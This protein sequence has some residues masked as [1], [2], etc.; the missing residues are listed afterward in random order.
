MYG[1]LFTVIVFLMSVFSIYSKDYNYTDFSYWWGGDSYNRY[2]FNYVRN[3]STSFFGGGGYEYYE[4]KKNRGNT[5]KLN[6]GFIS[7]NYVFSIKPFYFLKESGGYAFGAK[8][9]ADI[10]SGN[11]ELTRNLILNLGTVQKRGKIEHSD[12]LGEMQ[13][14]FNFDDHL[15]L[16]ARSSYNFKP[17]KIITPFDY[18]SFWGYNYLGTIND[19]FYSDI[20]FGYGRSFKPDFNSYLY[21]SFDRINTSGDDINSYLIGL[22]TYLDDDEK[23]FIDLDYNYADFKKNDNEKHY[24]LIMGVVF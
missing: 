11:Q 12:F 18:S 7:K 13:I 20:G 24:R 14:E 3:I 9:G 19:T 4:D 16:S 1:F 2:N 15:F 6:A 17:K 21:F 10:I 8:G 23:Y 22:K 5:I